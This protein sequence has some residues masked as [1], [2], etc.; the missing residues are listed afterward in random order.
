MNQK[1][2]KNFQ[3][4]AAPV[5]K[6][7][8][9]SPSLPNPPTPPNRPGSP[10]APIPSNSNPPPHDLPRVMWEHQVTLYKPS[11]MNMLGAQGWE[12]VAV[13]GDNNPQETTYWAFLKRRII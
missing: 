6:L 7:T 12:L 3:N 13:V 11:K 1:N 8:P 2:E 10:V 4:P 9:S 5:E